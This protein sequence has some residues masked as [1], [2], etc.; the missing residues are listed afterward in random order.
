MLRTECNRIA[1]ACHLRD[2][3]VRHPCD[4][5]RLQGNE[6]RF[7]NRQVEVSRKH[8]SNG[9]HHQRR[10]FAVASSRELCH[11]LDLGSISGL[12]RQATR[13]RSAR[14]NTSIKAN[15]CNM[16]QHHTPSLD[17]LVRMNTWCKIIGSNLPNLGVQL[18]DAIDTRQK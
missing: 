11:H 12:T 6:K 10:N 5:L 18:T 2:S 1:A 14:L 7:G 3:L 17:A 9:L 4:E 13:H 15:R 16:T 8:G